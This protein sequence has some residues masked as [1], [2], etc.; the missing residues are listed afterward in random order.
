MR[1]LAWQ[2]THGEGAEPDGDLAAQLYFEAGMIFLERGDVSGV[3]IVIGRIEDPT[4][5]WDYE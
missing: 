1:D 5:I 4:D 3:L 2:I